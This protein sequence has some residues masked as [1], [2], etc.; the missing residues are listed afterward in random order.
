M[1]PPH[2]K[3]KRSEHFLMLFWVHK[4]PNLVTWIQP[5]QS[6]GIQTTYLSVHLYKNHK[7]SCDNTVNSPAHNTFHG[8]LEVI[9]KWHTV[10]ATEGIFV[11]GDCCDIF[12]FRQNAQ[13]KNIS[14]SY[15][16][17][18]CFYLSNQQYRSYHTVGLYTFQLMVI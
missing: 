2:H 8:L 15:W 5:T 3:I 14:I 7:T 6:C 16:E 12:I 18:G 4:I 13:S 10:V 17:C 11:T 1:L 9:V